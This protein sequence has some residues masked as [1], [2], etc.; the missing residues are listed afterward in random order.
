MTQLTFLYTKYNM[1]NTWNVDKWSK[2]KGV[3][4]LQLP[5]Q[6]EEN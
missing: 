1:I 2:F 5:N 6:W 4:Q 3:G